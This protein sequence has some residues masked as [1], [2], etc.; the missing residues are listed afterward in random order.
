MAAGA[1]QTARFE[2]LAQVNQ[3]CANVPTMS[4]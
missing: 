4:A 3:T 2:M 1:L